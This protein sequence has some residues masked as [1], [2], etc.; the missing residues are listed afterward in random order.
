MDC[1]FA[2]GDGVLSRADALLAKSGKVSAK[3]GA[4]IIPIP[5]TIIVDTCKKGRV[6]RPLFIWK[7]L[8]IKF[9]DASR[10]I[11]SSNKCP[12]R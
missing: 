8:T 1:S 4:I 10:I 3:R 9:F 2:L 11:I 5:K 12:L 6:Y 7:N